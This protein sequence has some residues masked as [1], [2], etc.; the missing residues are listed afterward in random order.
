MGTAVSRAK[1]VEGWARELQEG[2][3][4]LNSRSLSR[5]RFLVVG[6]LFWWYWGWLSTGGRARTSSAVSAISTTVAV[7]RRH[8]YTCCHLDDDRVR[9]HPTRRWLANRRTDR[10][11]QVLRICARSSAAGQANT[12]QRLCDA[13]AHRR[14]PRV[15]QG[16][17]GAVS[18]QELWTDG[19]YRWLPPGRRLFSKS[20]VWTGERGELHRTSVV[21]RCRK[22][23]KTQAGVQDHVRGVS[24]RGDTVCHWNMDLLRQHRKNRYGILNLELDSGSGT[25]MVIC[26]CCWMVDAWKD[27]W[28]FIGF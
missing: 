1:C 21:S 18:R 7:S 14:R 3:D 25:L 2:C 15:A 20:V 17:Q 13:R 26:W 16:S 12:Y 9:S 28:T 27:R 8:G 22:G 10:L 11:G 4:S 6:G 24:S 19:P 23:G 5:C